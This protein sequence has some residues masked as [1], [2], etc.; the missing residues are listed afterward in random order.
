[1]SS[2]KSFYLSNEYSSAMPS[3]KF[4]AR[5]TQA[6]AGCFEFYDTGWLE[7]SFEAIDIRGNLNLYK[8]MQAWCYVGFKRRD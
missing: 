7:K 8:P 5:N 2:G 4:A 3:D 6:F 1:M